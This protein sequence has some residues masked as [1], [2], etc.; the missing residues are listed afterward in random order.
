MS[1]ISFSCLIALA[2]TSIAVWDKREEKQASCL[3]SECREKLLSF[4]MRLAV[5]FSYGPFVMLWKF[6]SLCVLLSVFIMEQ[7]WV[8]SNA[9]PVSVEII[10]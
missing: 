1:L 8:L 2:R 9:F 3:V 7:C 4:T 6:P 5:G 10:T